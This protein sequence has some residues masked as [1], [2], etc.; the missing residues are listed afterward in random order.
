MPGERADGLAR[1]LQR[2]GGRLVRDGWENTCESRRSFEL[3]YHHWF[4]RLTGMAMG[5]VGDAM[6]LACLLFALRQGRQ[7]QR[8]QNAD[9]GNDHQQF[10]QSKSWGFVFDNAL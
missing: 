6:D 7:E 8:S 3:L 4:A 5:V 1:W 9:D 10:N 2:T